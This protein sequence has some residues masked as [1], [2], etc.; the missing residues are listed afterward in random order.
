[1]TTTE[2][3]LPTGTTATQREPAVQVRGLMKRYGGRAVVDGLD[4]DVARG[5]VFALLGPNG[6]GKTTTIEILEG[7]RRRDTGSVSV[8]GEDPAGAGRAWRSRIGVVSQ[9]EGVAQ[10]LTVREMLDHFAT[11][12]ATPRPTAELVATVGLE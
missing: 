1:M 5:E 8:L 12:H 3:T 7:V 10:E 2:A 9:S 6:A 4:L 11:Y